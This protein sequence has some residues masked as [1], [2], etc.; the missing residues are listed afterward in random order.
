MPEDPT[1]V[2]GDI[3]TS[4]Q[5]EPSTTES[6]TGGTEQPPEQATVQERIDWRKKQREDAELNAHVQSEIARARTRW[7]RQQLRATAQHAAQNEDADTAMAVARHV[8]QEQDEPEEGEVRSVDWARAADRVQPQLERMLQLDSEGRATNPYY[9]QL[10]QKVG[11]AEM[12]KKYA[13]DPVQF[14]NWVDD[15]I[16]E[17]RVDEKLKKVAPALAGAMAQDDAHARLRGMPQPL[18]GSNSANGS[19]TLEMYEGMTFEQRQ[20]LRQTNPRAIDDMIARAQR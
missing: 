12:D 18:G 10:H 5:T 9:V 1:V 4:S 3:E 8:A 16:M 15:Q 20:K 7:Q 6:E 19:L 2:S 14:V 13:E 11:R 17:M